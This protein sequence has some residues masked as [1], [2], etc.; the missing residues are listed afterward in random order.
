MSGI[1]VAFDSNDFYNIIVRID[2]I[3]P[4]FCAGIRIPAGC[5]FGGKK[6]SCM[7]FDDADV[8]TLFWDYELLRRNLF[9]MKRMDDTLRN[10]I[11]ITVY[12]R[13]YLPA[14]ADE[15][16]LFVDFLYMQICK[17]VQ[18]NDVGIITRCDGTCVT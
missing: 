7:Q 16:S 4:V 2:T 5:A 13:R 18:N 9:H 12:S 11:R 8:L 14:F 10:G 15:R 17:I 3:C 6:L 1:F